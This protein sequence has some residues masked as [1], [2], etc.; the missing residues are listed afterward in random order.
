MSIYV[1]TVPALARVEEELMCIGLLDFV[2]QD[3]QKN[4]Y[5]LHQ[6]PTISFLASHMVHINTRLIQKP[7]QICIGGFRLIKSS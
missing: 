5:D 1:Y 7:T 2:Y 4:K 6:K 3:C